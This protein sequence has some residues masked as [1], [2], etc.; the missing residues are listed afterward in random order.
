[1]AGTKSREARVREQAMEHSIGVTEMLTKGWSEGGSWLDE[2][3]LELAEEEDAG[4]GWAGRR[5]FKMGW[6]KEAYR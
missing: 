5:R 1:M 3:E 6:R 4:R 2:A